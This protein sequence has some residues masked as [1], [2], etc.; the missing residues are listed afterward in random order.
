VLWDALLL[1]F[2]HPEVSVLVIQSSASP[3]KSSRLVPQGDIRL[4]DHGGGD[5]M[6]A[7][8]AMSVWAQSHFTV[9]MSASANTFFVITTNGQRRA[10]LAIKIFNW[11]AQRCWAQASNF[12]RRCCSV[13]DFYFSF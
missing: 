9:G 10:H 6:I 13:S 7:F 3:P 4:P 5:V 12:D 1:V 11:L 8:I 2:A